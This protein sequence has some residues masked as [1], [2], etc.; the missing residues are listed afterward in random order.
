MPKCCH[1]GSWALS[2]GDM[3]SGAKVALCF[4]MVLI[5]LTVSLPSFLAC[6]PLVG[7]STSGGR[8]SLRHFCGGSLGQFC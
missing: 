6:F 8:C 1:V 7:L 3:F 4:L 5:I 2:A